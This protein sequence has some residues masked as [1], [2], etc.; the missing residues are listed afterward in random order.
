[1][2]CELLKEELVDFSST[3][4]PRTQIYRKSTRALP[5]AALLVASILVGL[6][7]RFMRNN[8]TDRPNVPKFIKVGIVRG[9]ATIA[10]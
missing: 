4:E 10:A 9:I 8:G 2:R 1:M 7:G 3:N 5:T 6:A